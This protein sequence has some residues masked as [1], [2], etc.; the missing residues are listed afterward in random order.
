MSITK[1]TMSV[2]CFMYRIESNLEVD[3]KILQVIWVAK[4]CHELID[5]T[6]PEVTEPPITQYLSEKKSSHT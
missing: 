1:I 5:L 4:H 3:K 2:Q 6:R